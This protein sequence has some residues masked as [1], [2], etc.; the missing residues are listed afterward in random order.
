MNDFPKV[1]FLR[2]G[3]ARNLAVGFADKEIDIK[4]IDIDFCGTYLHTTSNV[5]QTRPEQTHNT[6]TQQTP[7]P[8]WQIRSPLQ[9]HGFDDQDDRMCGQPG[10]GVGR[11]VCFL[12][13]GSNY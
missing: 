3:T 1:L 10:G 5:D 8:W 2:P 6:H 9:R 7:P 13:N 4:R 11:E 12:K